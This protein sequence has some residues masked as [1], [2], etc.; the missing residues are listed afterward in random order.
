V[1]GTAGAFIDEC[2]SHLGFVEGPNNDTPFGA[3]RGANFQPWCASFV[4][5]CLEQA[6]S[7]HG[8]LVYVPAIVA[9]YRDEQR[10]FTEPQ[11]GDLMCLWFPSKNRYAHVGAVESVDGD[12]VWTVEGNS[13]RAGLRTGGLVVRLHRR[14]RGTRTVFA[15]PPFQPGTM[16]LGFTSAATR[17]RQEDAV[18]FTLVRPQGGYIVVQEDGGVFTFD[19]APF[20]KSLP[21]F[22]IVHGFPI[23]AGAWTPSGNGYWLVGSDGAIFAF[24]DA[25]PILGSNVEPMRHHVGDRRISGLVATGPDS[26]RLMAQ[27]K[28]G[29]FD[30]F[31]LHA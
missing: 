6:G 7:G 24:G 8:R 14:W 19:N 2:R 18:P 9:T 27:E 1:T 31:D 15:R 12:A 11:P 5:F 29:D 25:P 3:S 26:V 21:S 10:L 22:E 28:P 30:S 17:H 13:N 16:P 4:S 20:F 23:V